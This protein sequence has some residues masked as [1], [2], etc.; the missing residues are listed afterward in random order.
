M[1]EES[2]YYRLVNVIVG[3]VSVEYHEYIGPD[4]CI[5]PDLSHDKDSKECKRN[6]DDKPYISDTTGN[7][8]VAKCKD[9]GMYKEDGVCKDTCASGFFKTVDGENICVNVC[10]ASEFAELPA[11]DGMPR[12]CVANCKQRF[13]EDPAPG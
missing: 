1:N 6:C 7:V 13:F 4:K 12:E 10:G 9:E 11:A 5:S 8:C 3:G 2:D